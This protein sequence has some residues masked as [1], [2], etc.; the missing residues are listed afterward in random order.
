MKRIFNPIL[1]PIGVLF[2]VLMCL[3]TNRANAQESNPIWQEQQTLAELNAAPVALIPYP[4]NVS[5]SRKNISLDQSL[6]F[7]SIGESE[8]FIDTYIKG[9]FAESGIELLVSKAEKPFVVL[10]I[11]TDNSLAKNAE[12]YWLTVDDSGIK[13]KA[14]QAAG[15]FYG[16]QTLRQLIQQDKGE[17][18]IA[19]CEIHDWP[20]FA[21]RGFLFDTGRNFLSAEELKKTIDRFAQYKFNTFHWHLTDN[22]AWRPESKR[23]PELNKPSFRRAGRDPD[24]SYSFEVIREIIRFAKKR[25]IRVIPELDMPGHSQFFDKTFGFHMS[26]EKGMAI[27]EDL[28]DEFC[29]EISKDD[30]PVIHIGSDEIGIKNPDEFISRMTARL[31]HH[32]RKAVVWDPGLKPLNGTIQQIWYDD[33]RIVSKHHQNR[34]P[35]ID[36]YAGYLNADSPEWLVQRYYFQQVCREKQGDAWALGGILCCWNDVRVDDKSKIFLHNPVWP[37]AL[38]YSEAI[39]R[40]RSQY[41][42]QYMHTLPNKESAAAQY[43]QQFEKRMAEHRS[44]FFNQMPF[45][46][47]RHSDIEWKMSLPKSYSDKETTQIEQIAFGRRVKGGLIKPGEWLGQNQWADSTRQVVYL[48]S[49]INTEMKADYYAIIGFE[50]PARSNRQSAGIPENGEWDA[51]GGFVQINGNKLKG[52]QWKHAGQ[53]RYLKPTWH[54]P[55]NE[56]PYTDEEFY[57]SRTPSKINLKRGHNEIVVCIPKT[58]AKQNWQFVFIP[59]KKTPSGSWIRDESIHIKP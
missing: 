56:I 47:V 51:N 30:C 31:A 37:G 35:Y 52:P 53:N 59:V 48:K 15:L 40:G 45:P 39:W 28:I 49:V 3:V 6:V 14:P 32:G 21:L 24:S 17:V 4:Q 23:Y 2:L 46:Y 43:F 18:W 12:E 19:A 27:L 9:L 50:S 22:P 41:T 10:E 1:F 29:A 8:P 13:I 36:S 58:Y 57:W 54:K 42:E 33:G 20:A 16:I 34:N 5:W 11:L 7:K 38:A 44:R 26:S 25:H 55:A